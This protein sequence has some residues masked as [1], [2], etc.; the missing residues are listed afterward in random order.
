M[1][2][3]IHEIFPKRLQQARKMRGLSL[4][5]LSKEM[6]QIVS[7]QAINKYEQ[8]KMMPDSRVLLALA[9]SLGVKV[10]FFFRPYAVS[11]DNIEFR[12][13]SKFSPAKAQSL[14]ERVHE[15][16]ERYLEIEQISG[17]AHE[18]NLERK[19]VSTTQDAIAFAGEVRNALQLGTDGISNVIEVLEDNNI[20]I[21]EIAEDSAFDGLSGYVNGNIPIIVVNKTFNAERKR[22]T[23][24]HE[25]GHLLMIFSDDMDQ[26]SV[27]RL[28]NA[29]ANEMLLPYSVLTSKI[30][31]KRHDI[32]LAELKDIQIQFGISVDAIMFTLHQHGVISDQRY[33][34]FNIKKN[35]NADF[36]T[37]IEASR[38]AEK[39]SGRFFRMVYRALADE[40]ISISKAAV[41]LNTSVE[42]VNAQ[43]QLV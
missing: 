42:K 40:I 43:L 10:D 33:R 18:F 5:N 9:A 8:G 17:T 22:F 31:E 28:C 41:L 15:E 13:K 2:Q 24:L 1:S 37:Q 16:L 32:S 35:M 36:K 30:G 19:M 11:I 14:S 25:L 20:K 21:I 4:D 23:A 34:T 26:K 39:S 6:N 29:F 7:R 27:E 12:K 38:F 3:V